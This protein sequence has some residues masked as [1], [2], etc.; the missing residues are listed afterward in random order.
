MLAMEMA[1][2]NAERQREYRGR[3]KMHEG[4]K[5]L[6][7]ERKKTKT[8]LQ[9]NQRT[10]QDRIQGTHGNSKNESTRTSFIRKTNFSL[11]SGHPFSNSRATFTISFDCFH[12]ISQPR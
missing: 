12:V 5:Y 3:K 8:I 7:K 2:I 6:E 11:D 10:F 9:G 1:K 4:P